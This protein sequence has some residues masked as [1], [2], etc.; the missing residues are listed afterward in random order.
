M[1]DLQAHLRTHDRYSK[2]LSASFQQ[3]ASGAGTAGGTSP[4][5]RWSRR[6]KAV[7]LPAVTAILSPGLRRARELTALL[8]L[9]ALPVL[10]VFMLAPASGSAATPST[11]AHGTAPSQ[12]EAAHAAIASFVAH[13]KTSSSRE[14]TLEAASVQAASVDNL[15][16]WTDADDPAGLLDFS[17]VSL[18]C[19]SATQELAI[20]DTFYRP[21]SGLS[22]GAADSLMAFLDTDLNAS[23]GYPING[24]GAD[25]LVNYGY[26][27][28]TG[29]TCTV[30]RSPSSDSAT[31]SVM[32]TRSV[33]YDGSQPSS[34]SLSTHI[35]YSWI[36]NPSQ[37]RFFEASLC[38]S[39]GGTQ[40][41]DFIPD[42]PA[43]GIYEISS[44]SSTTTTT[45][46]PPLTTTT[47]PPT[48]TTTNPPSTTTTTRPPTAFPDVLSTHSYYAAITDLA[49]RAIIGGFPDGSFRP[50]AN[51]IRQQL[52]KVVIV[53]IDKNSGEKAVAVSD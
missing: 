18:G 17:S 1:L 19:V 5:R 31:W 42:L 36:G 53:T 6:G 50:E 30:L 8:G 2:V 23:S 41:D 3:P 37:F 46:L 22:L 38:N 52:R 43:R 29:Y 4:W 21:F 47:L 14:I 20:L 48:T 49:D 26:A 44:P 7:I 32:G 15:L 33:V 12:M 11:G 27:A 16:S 13:Q 39:S 24:I 51:V 45:S 35:P 28:S 10:L 40:V 34:D 9:A 25:Y